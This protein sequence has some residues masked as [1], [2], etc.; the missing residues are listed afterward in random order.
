MFAKSA[1]LLASVMGIQAASLPGLLPARGWD[2]HI[3]CGTTQDANLSACQ[4]LLDNWQQD[5]R[6]TLHCTYH[7]TGS[8]WNVASVEG[9]S[10]Y[11]TNINAESSAVK[12]AVQALMGC[13][14][15]DKGK[16]NGLTTLSDG[17]GVCI[18]G[19]DGCGD[20]FDDGDFNP[21]RARDVVEVEPRQKAD[22][23]G[24]IAELVNA[25]LGGHSAD[26]TARA[27]TVKNVRDGL[28][29]EYKRN[30]VVCHT[31]HEAHWDGVQGVDWYHEHFEVDIQIGGTIGYEVYVAKG[32]TF[33]R[34]GDGGEINWGWNGVLARDS[35]ENG[36]KLTFAT[37]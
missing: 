11:I 21:P 7:A 29:D 33:K 22:I 34:K 2:N 13:A 8:A 19:N 4:S 3:S 26:D 20:C 9:C 36:S 28:A 14:A 10:V 23:A 32:G 17:S 35:E 31:D 27:N 18:G 12:E 25:I 30:V 16:V 5:L 37:R 15:V 24:S 1:L 6:D